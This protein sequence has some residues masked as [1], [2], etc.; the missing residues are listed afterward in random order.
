VCLASNG[1][2][3]TIE[4]K[5]ELDRIRLKNKANLVVSRESPVRDEARLALLVRSAL[6]AL[7]PAVAMGKDA[8]VL[9][10]DDVEHYDA[11]EAP[12]FFDSLRWLSAGRGKD[13]VFLNTPG[14]LETGRHLAC[15]E[16]V[17]RLQKGALPIPAHAARKDVLVPE[18]VRS[19]V[20]RRFAVYGVYV[21]CTIVDGASHS[22]EVE[23]PA[24]AACFELPAELVDVFY[25]RFPPTKR[26]R[27]I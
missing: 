12:P 2:V 25:G 13:R 6:V 9:S 16:F 1:D 14:V 19:R 20:R 7:Q 5:A 11:G 18:L 4:T 17:V 22:V 23:F 21:D 15:G 26:K 8:Y 3:L 24:D 10:A 27:A